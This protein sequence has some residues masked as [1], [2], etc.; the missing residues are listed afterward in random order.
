[1]IKFLNLFKEYILEKLPQIVFVS[2]TVVFFIHSFYDIGLLADGTWIFINILTNP[3]SD[4]AC[5]LFGIIALTLPQVVAIKMGIINFNFLIFLHAFWYY[6]IT[7]ICLFAAYLLIPKDKKNLFQFTL[8]SYLFC[9]NAAG[10]FITNESFLCAGLFWIIYIIFTFEKFELLS[11]SKFIIVLLCSVLLIKNYQSAAVF[12]ALFILYLFINTDIKKIFYENKRKFFMFLLLISVFVLSI[13]NVYSKYIYYKQEIFFPVSHFLSDVNLIP[14]CFAIMIIILISVNLFYN[15]KMQRLVM[16]VCFSV[17]FYIMFYYKFIYSVGN[18]R[19]F[20]FIMPL[21]LSAIFMY[22]YKKNIKVN[23]HLLKLLNLSLLIIFTVNFHIAA[24]KWQN[25]VDKTHLELKTN[26]GLLK[27][28]NSPLLFQEG[29]HLHPAFSIILQ[30]KRGISNINSIFYIS[31]E[32]HFTYP[33]KQFNLALSKETLPD[34]TKF[35]IT[36][37]DELL[38]KIEENSKLNSKINETLR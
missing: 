32:N 15:Y 29:F 3:F 2:L 35:G 1:M 10:L 9:L 16:F 20:N 38:K 8:F 19:F 5:R 13:L 22:V 36:Y 34:L 4:V 17:L 27:A 12:A 24:V 18:F 14:L 23:Y 33:L 25:C 37:S 28:E 6:F 31:D 26:A 7:V 30:K 11:Y 21:L